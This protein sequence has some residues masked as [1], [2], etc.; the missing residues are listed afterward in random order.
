MNRQVLDDTESRFAA[1]VQALTSAGYV[2][3][4]IAFALL[5]RAYELVE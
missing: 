2:H 3:S 5:A 1:Y 4:D